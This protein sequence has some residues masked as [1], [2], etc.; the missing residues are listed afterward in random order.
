VSVRTGNDECRM[1]KIENEEPM[2]IA[3]LL[4]P[5]LS[6]TARA[7]PATEG[8][9]ARGR[10]RQRGNKAKRQQGSKAARQRGKE[11]VGVRDSAR[12]AE[13]PKVHSTRGAGFWDVLPNSAMRDNPVTLAMRGDIDRLRVHTE[14]ARN[15]QPGGLRGRFGGDIVF[16]LLVASGKE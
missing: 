13:I 10:K 6:P 11:G 4:C 8:T 5:A 15:G 7:T 2:A 3:K 14:D 1:A 16:T 12:H 9:E